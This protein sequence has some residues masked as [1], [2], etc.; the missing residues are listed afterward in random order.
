[1]QQQ[2]SA[3]RQQAKDAPR[4]RDRIAEVP[5]PHSRVVPHRVRTT[6]LTATASRHRDLHRVRTTALT[7]TVSRV[8]PHPHR[9]RTTA[10]TVTV[11]DL[12]RVRIASTVTVSRVVPHP[13]RVR[14][15]LTVTAAVRTTRDLTTI[16]DII[17]EA[18]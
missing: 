14:I 2:T 12:H 5:H 3:H 16:T 4:S 6:A 8:V 13:H 10:S 7:A 17:P 11:R 9:V 15:A 1:M 18:A